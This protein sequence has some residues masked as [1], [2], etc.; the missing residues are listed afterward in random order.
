MFEIDQ[1]WSSLTFFLEPSRAK[2]LESEIN[3]AEPSQKAQIEMGWS[4]AEP[5]SLN[6]KLME[7]SRAK[8]LEFEINGAESSQKA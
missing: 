7:P 4:R 1:G 5:K 2:K 6:L 3:G 8:K